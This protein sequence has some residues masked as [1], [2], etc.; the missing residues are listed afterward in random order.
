MKFKNKFHIGL[1][2]Y[3]CFGV[4]LFVYVLPSIYIGYSPCPDNA[5]VPNP[6]ILDGPAF[7]YEEYPLFTK[8]ALWF[9]QQKRTRLF[10]SILFVAFLFVLHL[11]NLDMT[12]KMIFCQVVMWI[13]LAVFVL[14]FLGLFSILLRF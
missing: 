11:I 3:T 5:L 1:F 7:N 9:A 12:W 2:L 13:S 14:N 8:T 6:T 10:F 4:F